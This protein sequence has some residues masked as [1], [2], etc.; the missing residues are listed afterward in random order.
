MPNWWDKYTQDQGTPE[1]QNTQGPVP[2]V[3][4]GFS[5]TTNSGLEELNQLNE[6]KR[7]NEVETARRGAEAQGLQ[8]I[9]NKDRSQAYDAG[10]AALETKKLLNIYKQI[11]EMPTT[12]N[13]HT[14]PLANRWLAMG[15]VIRDILP[16]GV[17]D[18]F[19]PSDKA[20]SSAELQQKLGQVLATSATKELTSRPSQFEFMSNI[21]TS[22]GIQ[23]RPETRRNLVGVLNA[24]ADRLIELGRHAVEDETYQDYVKNKNRIYT[25]PKYDY[26]MSEEL[27]QPKNKA[28]TLPQS[29]EIA[30][31]VRRRINNQ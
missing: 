22:P 19:F 16:K 29:I 17:G 28:E 3:G 12:E 24:H 18:T 25:D 11:E 6:F 30:P 4:Q 31:G 2:P 21:A 7:Q 23:V 9:R 5:P 20:V 26:K 1:P 13:I 10:N 27:M 8:E 15:Q 14:G